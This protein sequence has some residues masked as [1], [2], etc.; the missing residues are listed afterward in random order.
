MVTSLEADEEMLVTKLGL[1]SLSG[2]GS[3]LAGGSPSSSHLRVRAGLRVSLASPV[4]PGS[5]LVT[6]SPRSHRRGGGCAVTGYFSV[7]W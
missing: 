4:L 7:L 5:P 2:E 1:H 3:V 6:A